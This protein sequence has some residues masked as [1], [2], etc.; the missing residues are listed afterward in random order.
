MP[1][2]PSV[3]LSD[4]V[5]LVRNELIG[6]VIPQNS[7]NLSIEWCFG[8][9]PSKSFYE[10]LVKCTYIDQDTYRLPTQHAMQPGL[11]GSW[12]KH[13]WRQK[14]MVPDRLWY[15]TDCAVRT[16]HSH[17]PARPDARQI[18]S[19]SGELQT[20]GNSICLCVF[21]VLLWPPKR[22]PWTAYVI[23]ILSTSPT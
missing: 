3:Y 6:F 11:A 21:G 22:P 12:S 20:G 5:C 19:L 18:F 13:A 16:V 9:I 4:L 10:V 14:L 1:S 23:C 15:R 2:M 7:Q 8:D 17:V